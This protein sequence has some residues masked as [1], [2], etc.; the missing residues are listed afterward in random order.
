MRKCVL[1]LVLVFVAGASSLQAGEHLVSQAAASQ[2]LRSA[3]EQRTADLAT[4][5]STLLDPEVSAAARRLGYDAGRLAGN[6]AVLSSEE[7][8]DL[9]VRSERLRL[10]PA[11]GLDSDVRQ[12]LIVFLIVAIVIL[13][14]QAVD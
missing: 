14:L 9:A 10:D 7:L 3:A 6:A 12:L 5:R 1:S 2:R 8:R 13:V 4:L 11:A